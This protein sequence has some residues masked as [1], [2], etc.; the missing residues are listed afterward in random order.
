M[1]FKN[2]SLAVFVLV[3]ICVFLRRL[4]PETI[5]LKNLSFGNRLWNNIEYISR[6]EY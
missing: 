2:V 3:F 1:I 5:C 4:V 6:L